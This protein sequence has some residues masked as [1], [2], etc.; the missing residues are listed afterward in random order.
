MKSKKAQFYAFAILFLTILALGVLSLSGKQGYKSSSG[1]EHL[2]NNYN[3]EKQRVLNYALLNDKDVFETMRNFSQDFIE[4]EP[5]QKENLEIIGLVSYNQTIEVFSYFKEKIE[6][7]NNFNLSYG[8]K[9]KTNQ[10]SLIIT[11]NKKDYAFGLNLS[12]IEIQNLLRAEKNRNIQ[13]AQD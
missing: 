11:L 2:R 5:A 8:Q 1:F 3:Q 4:T 12:Q 9:Q 6:V 10:T 13:I 7:K